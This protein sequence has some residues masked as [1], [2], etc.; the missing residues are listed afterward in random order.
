MQ[1]NAFSLHGLRHCPRLCSRICYCTLGANYGHM[2]S[3]TVIRIDRNPGRLVVMRRD[4]WLVLQNSTFLENDRY[5]SSQLL[6]SCD[7]AGYVTSVR[8]SFS[9]AV[10][11]SEEWAGRKPSGYNGRPRS[12]WTVKQK[13]IINSAVELVVKLR[14][15]IMHSSHPNRIAL[16]RVAR[17]CRSWC[18]KLV[19]W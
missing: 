10:P 7:D 9:A 17:A 11:G 16:R 5:V 1:L 4:L 14:P 15:L 6:P 19:Q 8:D 12:Y 2:V 3:L 18:A 13:S